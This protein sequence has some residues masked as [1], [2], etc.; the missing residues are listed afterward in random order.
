MAD[1]MQDDCCL[2]DLS[3]VDTYG[4]DLVDN[5]VGVEEESKE[6]EIEDE[7]LII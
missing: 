3:D 5:E 2:D 1:A 7:E 4:G 6:E